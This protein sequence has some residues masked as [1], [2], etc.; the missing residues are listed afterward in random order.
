MDTI[1]GFFCAV[2]LLFYAVARPGVKRAGISLPTFYLGGLTLYAIGAVCLSVSDSDQGARAVT[3]MSETALFSG[4]M[5]SIIGLLL[6]ERNYPG[7]YTRH[8]LASWTLTRSEQAMIYWGLTISALVCAGFSIEV[9]RNQTIS[10]LLA[11]VFSVSD[12]KNLL[13]ARKAITTGSEGYFAPGI[14]KQF[15]DL[16]VPILL[17]A[18]ILIAT[19]QSLD[20]RHKVIVFA[21]AASAVIAMLLSGVR[22][23][24]FLFFITL[25][26]AYAMAQRVYGKMSRRK[27]RRQILFVV[28]ALLLYGVLTVLLGRASND[29][30]PL[31]LALNILGNLFDRIVTTVPRINIDTYT[32]WVGLSTTHGEQWLADLRGIL[33]GA[34]PVTLYNILHQYIGGSLE[35]NASLGLPV[36]VWLNWGWLGLVIVPFFYGLFL[37]YFDSKLSTMRSP[38]AFGIK[39]TFALALV[40]IYS[41][42]GFLLYGGGVSILLYLYLNWIRGTEASHMPRHFARQPSTVV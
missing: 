6:L 10:T 30:S 33:P 40:K 23:N 36:D 39:I 25:Y 20:F 2:A 26:V 21:A 14:V 1:F 27:K 7:D 35:G 12:S 41:P 31:S 29:G 22:S 24:L 28:I 11:D 18:I 38:V 19:R 5:G 42:I 3:V 32:Y 15:R 34:P 37:V 17:S 8:S 16:L 13:E 9:L 4:T